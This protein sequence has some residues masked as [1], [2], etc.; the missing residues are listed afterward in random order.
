MRNWHHN[1]HLPV[2]VEGGLLFPPWGRKDAQACVAR[3][4]ANGLWADF[5]TYPRDIGVF[6]LVIP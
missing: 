2:E 6:V 4:R 1:D 3:C 5:G